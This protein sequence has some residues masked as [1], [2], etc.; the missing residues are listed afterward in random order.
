ML[1]QERRTL[2]RQAALHSGAVDVRTLVDRFQVSATTIRRD[3]S[4]LADGGS[5]RRVHGGAIALATPSRSGPGDPRTAHADTAAAKEAVA[6]SAAALV[7]P[8]M[9]VGVTAGTTALAVARHLMAVPELTLVTNSLPVAELALARSREG[10]ARPPA[11]LMLGGSPTPTAGLV[12]PLADQALRSLHVDVLITGAYGV[13]A[14]V[15]LTTPDLTEALTNQAF[16]RA[17]RT[18]VAVADHTKWGVAGPA[19][20]AD[21]GDVHCF[22]TDDQLAVDAQRTLRA[23]V[24]AL[25]VAPVATGG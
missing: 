9:V 19:R 7:E 13:T 10:G 18:V 17:A 20:F 16:I 12:G 2:I 1:R 23:R 3:L 15:G 22:V 14:R 11:L 4:T 24:G 25:W 8:G 21:L 6:R 5:M